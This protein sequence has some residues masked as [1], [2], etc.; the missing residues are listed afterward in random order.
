MKQ[1]VIRKR[2]SERGSYARRFI[3]EEIIKNEINKNDINKD[4][5]VE[6][7]KDSDNRKNVIETIQEYM[8]RGNSLQNAVELVMKDK[9]LIEPFDY[10]VK[11]GLDLRQC[12]TNWVT[13]NEITERKRKVFEER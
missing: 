1:E 10:L 9:G 2:V 4:K 13:R 12:F 11:N 3:E 8:A 5:K 7:A 6:I